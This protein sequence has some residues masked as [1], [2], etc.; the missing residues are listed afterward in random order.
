M[1]ISSS[2]AISSGMVKSKKGNKL[3][4]SKY[5]GKSSIDITIGEV[6]YHDEKSAKV[7]CKKCHK[8]LP[9]ETA[10]VISNELI[11]I[12]VG[13]IA[14]VFLKNRMSNKGVL[15]FNTGI[16]DGG[17]K[18]YIS[19]LVTNLSLYP[20]NLK[21]KESHFFRIV[22]QR[23]EKDD[24]IPYEPKKSISLNKYKK[25][26]ID[27]LERLPKFFL[28]PDGIKE[29]INKE[30]NSKVL[31]IGLD[32]LTKVFLIFGLIFVF[33]P[34]ISQLL[35]NVVS[36]SESDRNVS[37]IILN[38]ERKIHE[39]TKEIERLNAIGMVEKD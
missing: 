14:Y 34:P 37:E 20:V 39:N 6:L 21:G 29:Q 31:N 15:A 4:I 13:Y 2:E 17:Y 10:Y 33:V 35:L 30:I 27:E 25:Y 18:G 28:N 5:A 7:K 32:N 9:Q 8:L 12:P 3:D 16:I 36:S 23:V 19:T 24:S 11:D 38:L 26:K 1:Q 22:F